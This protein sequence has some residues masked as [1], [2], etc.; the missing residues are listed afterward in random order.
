MPPY[1]A[2]PAEMETMMQQQELAHSTQVWP[3]KA[4]SPSPVPPRKDNNYNGNGEAD[5]GS[6]LN[7]N[8]YNSDGRSD[9]SSVSFSAKK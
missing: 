8:P 5:K 7:D 6:E 3:A 4:L 2:P 1:K 9:S